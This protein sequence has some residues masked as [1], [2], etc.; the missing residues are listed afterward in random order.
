MRLQRGKRIQIGLEAR[1]LGRGLDRKGH[2]IVGSY[3]RGPDDRNLDA[4]LS[5]ERIRGE[6]TPGAKVPPGGEMQLF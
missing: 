5:E 6:R 1:V 4:G 3:C 2:R